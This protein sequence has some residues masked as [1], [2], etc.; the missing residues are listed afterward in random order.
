VDIPENQWIELL[1]KAVEGNI[2]SKN[3]I[4]ELHKIL[5]QAL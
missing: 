3:F 1:S 4:K 5:S 2:F